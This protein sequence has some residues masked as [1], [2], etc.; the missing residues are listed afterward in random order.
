[1]EI[2][3]IREF[4]NNDVKNKPAQEVH[5]VF[6]RMFKDMKNTKLRKYI[7]QSVS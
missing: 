6:H 7:F 1:M 4:W 5:L 2:E 3:N